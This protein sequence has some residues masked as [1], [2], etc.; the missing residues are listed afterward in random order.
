MLTITHQLPDGFLTIEP[1][2]LDE[3]LRGPTLIHLEGDNPRP[4]FVSVL[5][6]GNES[7]GLLAIQALLRRYQDETLPRA[8]SIFVGNV[9]AAALKQRRLEG[10]PD[11]NRIWGDGETGP[12]GEMVKQVMAEMTA[13]RPFASI[14]IHNNTGLNPHYACINELDNRFLRL[15]TLFS[16]TVVYFT[17]PEGV[18]SLAFARLCPAVTLECGQPDQPYGVEHASHFVDTVLKLDGLAD[19]PLSNSE[20]DL[21]HTMAVMK[22]P[23]PFSFGFDSDEVDITLQS[24][25]DHYNFT[26]LPAGTCF[27]QI[28]RPEARLSCIGENGEDLAE[29]Y[30]NYEHGKI[31]LARPAM[32]AMLT[33][34][35]RIIRQDCLGY[36]MERIRL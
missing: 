10:Q 23:E 15:A 20:Y 26:E 13:R 18:Q 30:F 33:L 5:L 19:T 1:Q 22:I 14:D 16:R 4:L 35:E 32:P 11:Y 17:K 34:D 27:G 28:H 24:E 29:R 3:V 25:I 2:R 8:L 7:T 12:E 21:F 36:L 6:H 9:A 31:E